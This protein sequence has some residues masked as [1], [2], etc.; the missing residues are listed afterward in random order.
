MAFYIMGTAGHID[1]GKTTLI[2]LLSGIETDRLPEEKDRGMSIDL[3]YAYVRLPSG[4]IAGIV[5]VPGHERFLRN[6]LAGVSGLDFI[7]LVVSAA[8]GIKPQT[9]EHTEILDLL[10]IK[11]GIV[12][13]N[14]VDLVD[15]K[16]LEKRLAETKDFVAGTFLRDAP[17]L[18]V[19]SLTGE[20]RDRLIENI[21]ALL[22]TIPP[23]ETEK[24]FRM[25]VDRIFSKQ[26]FGT[27]VA[28]SLLS[29]K[30]K[31]GDRVSLMPVGIECKVRTIG[32]YN[33]EVSLALA[34][35]RVA[36]NLSGIDRKDVRRGYELCSPGYL[37]PTSLVDGK[38]KV[39]SESPR[40]VRNNVPVRVYIGTGEYMGKIK[41][42]EK[43]EIAPADEGFVQ[44]A[45]AEPCVCMRGDH[46]IIRNSSALFTLGGGIIV[47]PYP[48]RHRRGREDV[49]EVLKKKESTDF[50]EVLMG[51][52]ISEPETTFT[53]A[54]LAQRVQ[55]S[56]SEICSAL[57]LLSAAGE[58]HHL[59][60]KNCYA[61][62][63][64]YERIRDGILSSLEKMQ[65]GSP[66]KQGWKR[67]EIFKFTGFSRKEIFERIIEE[68][69]AAA[70]LKSES[71]VLSTKD[72][73]AALEE[74]YE[75]IRKKFEKM[76]QDMGFSPDFRADLVKKLSVDEKS[77]KVVED[78]MINSGELKKI[79]HEFLLLS[80]SLEKAK[81][82]IADHISSHGGIGP[83]E[84]RDLLKT[85][86][87]Y[88]IPL[89]EFMDQ[90]RF[91]K[92]T[93]DRRILY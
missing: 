18:E 30:I 58:I 57:D 54:A 93:G 9:V 40:P 92:R 72:H 61:R 83:A 13:L 34:G 11:G 70:L 76:L 24:E 35:Q 91:T 19:S 59:A 12:A 65:K 26:G 44:L 50:S 48:T 47:D 81:K 31:K 66:W 63:S 67:E 51:Q 5:D 55:I 28:G 8:E 89:L 71:G 38:L 60:L 29:G 49:I 43:D 6:M 56:E 7:V 90:I 69:L 45:I 53:A 37:R 41:I 33:S 22:K 84:A 78:F 52:F 20:G 62:Q 77:F 4:N 16:E 42:L 88:V 39:L 68:L 17:I 1:H 3:G 80:S 32:V 85:S 74:R 23:R 86:R 79:S 87:K 64:D 82:L 36:L 2:K 21:D 73:R 14:K 75:I 10:E 27:V 25:P 46:F 15:R